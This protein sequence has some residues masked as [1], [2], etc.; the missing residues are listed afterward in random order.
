LIARTGNTQGIKFKI[1]PPTKAAAKATA[2]EAKEAVAV[3]GAAAFAASAAANAGLTAPAASALASAG[4]V[5]CTRD[6]DCPPPQ[7]CE[8]LIQQCH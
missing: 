6:D 7:T 4:H 3:T 8:L 5:P 2:K 1:K